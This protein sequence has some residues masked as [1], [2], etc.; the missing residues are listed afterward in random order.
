MMRTI[1]INQEIERIISANIL[2]DLLILLLY[3]LN[4]I[5]YKQE[6]VYKIPLNKHAK[7]G[8][9]SKKNNIIIEIYFFSN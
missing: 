1:W 6:Q 2:I 5:V 7:I 8:K 9:S 4:K 3:G